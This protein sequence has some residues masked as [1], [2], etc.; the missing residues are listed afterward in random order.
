MSAVLVL[1]VHNLEVV[2]RDVRS[3][4]EVRGMDTPAQHV[5]A[6]QHGYSYIRQCKQTS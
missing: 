3:I 2:V 1:D 5:H 6:V 4:L